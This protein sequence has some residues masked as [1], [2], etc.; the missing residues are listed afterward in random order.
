M[1]YILTVCSEATNVIS[2]HTVRGLSPYPGLE[3]SD[4]IKPMV[5]QHLS[6]GEERGVVVVINRSKVRFKSLY[7]EYPF[8]FLSN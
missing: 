7:L 8:P 5:L 3:V 4:I 2:L 1:A 6:F